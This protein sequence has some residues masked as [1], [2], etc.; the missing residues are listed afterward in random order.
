MVSADDQSALSF[1]CSCGW[2][3]PDAKDALELQAAGQIWGFSECV[4]WLA[5]PVRPT[6][7]GGFLLSPDLP[8]PGETRLILAQFPFFA[9]RGQP[10]WCLYVPP[11]SFY[12]GWADH[13]DELARSAIVQCQMREVR[14]VE[15][16]SA[17]VLVDVVDVMLLPEIG[18]RVEAQSPAG[19]RIWTDFP[20]ERVDTLR[21]GSFSLV[22]GQEF[23]GDSQKSFL[24]EERDGQ[25]HL[26]LEQERSLH[27][28]FLF[29]RNS[30][31][32]TAARVRLQQMME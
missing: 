15:T 19:D 4:E 23:Q 3:G 12:N 20:S 8:A 10:F 6:V 28:D 30:P 11:L 27:A 24:F 18:R 9:R 17:Q 13:P 2:N 7:T 5:T 21:H 22:Q 32:N 1:R 31:L 25:T 29:V 16:R 14:D 26:I